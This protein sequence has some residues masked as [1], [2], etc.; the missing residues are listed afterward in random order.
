MFTNFDE[1]KLGVE[2]R[3][4]DRQIDKLMAVQEAYSNLCDEL[5]FKSEA[6]NLVNKK[7]W[8]NSARLKVLFSIQE[9]IDNIIEM[10]NKK[11]TA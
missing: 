9:N 5:P 11:A 8:E 1:L 7:Y 2:S 4:L 6:W 3:R 10:G